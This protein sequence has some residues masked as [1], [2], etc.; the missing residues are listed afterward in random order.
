M[1]LGGSQTAILADLE[2][3]WLYAIENLLKIPKS[4]LPKF[5]AVLIIPALYKRSLIKHYMVTANVKRGWCQ[6]NDAWFLCH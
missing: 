5:R 4:E 1:F 3:I 2:T 6:C